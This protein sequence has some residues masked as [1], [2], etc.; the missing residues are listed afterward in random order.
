MNPVKSK[1][2]RTS[3]TVILGK[4]ENKTQ[5]INMKTIISQLSFINRLS[6]VQRCH[7]YQVKLGAQI[8]FN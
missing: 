8:W 6:F 5:K 3:D 4:G 2:S 1:K 7:G